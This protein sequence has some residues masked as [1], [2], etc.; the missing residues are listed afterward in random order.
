MDRIDVFAASN[1]HKSFPKIKLIFSFYISHT[2]NKTMNS[3][4][5]IKALLFAIYYALLFI[6]VLVV[7][8][9]TKKI[10]FKY[11]FDSLPI[12]ALLYMFHLYVCL[13]PMKGGLYLLA[14][15][16]LLMAPIVLQCYKIQI[17]GVTGKLNKM[18]ENN[19]FLKV[20][21]DQENQ[22]PPRFY[23]KNSS[24]L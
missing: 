19:F 7:M 16:T 10:R 18:T 17:V 4:F 21:L 22:Q 12:V 5:W 15:S 6:V 20:V 8:L 24:F 11:K 13:G 2:P 14:P 1:L 23:M 3:L 9:N